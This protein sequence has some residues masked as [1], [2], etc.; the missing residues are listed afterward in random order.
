MKP[1]QDVTT[2]TQDNIETSITN[3]TRVTGWSPAETTAALEVA[4]YDQNEDVIL[5]M[6]DW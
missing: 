4:N 1:V 3:I 2:H 5:I 6:V